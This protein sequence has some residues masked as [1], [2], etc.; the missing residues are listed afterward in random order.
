MAFSAAGNYKMKHLVKLVLTLACCH[1]P[2]AI[3]AA[4]RTNDELFQYIKETN[5][6]H[7]GI[8]HL[9]SIGKSK[10]GIVLYKCH[11]NGVHPGLFTLKW[12]HYGKPRSVLSLVSIKCI[13]DRNKSELFARANAVAF[14]RFP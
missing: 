1:P 9:Y 7:P 14:C 4:Y 6:L 3:K 11:C 5:L 13:S 10:Q 2:L 12:F 8:T